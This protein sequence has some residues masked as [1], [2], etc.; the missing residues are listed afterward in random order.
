M[1]V[2][3]EA[4]D[5]TLDSQ[6]VMIYKLRDAIGT[7]VVLPDPIAVTT[8]WF[9]M[10]LLLV[11]AVVVRRVRAGVIGIVLAPARRQHGG[12]MTRITIKDWIGNETVAATE[13][14][15]EG[16]TDITMMIEGDDQDRGN[17]KM[18]RDDVHG[19]N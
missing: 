6:D 18:G 3:V 7:L 9:S 2:V 19:L 11:V 8:V 10:M 15:M 17:V 16:G 1:V 5:S 12:A 13:T 14:E 4:V